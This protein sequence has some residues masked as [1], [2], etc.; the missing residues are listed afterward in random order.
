VELRT[1]FKYL[2]QYLF[3]VR[4]PLLLG[5]A[6]MAFP[7][8]APWKAPTFLGNLFQLGWRDIALVTF[9]ACLCAWSI[10]YTRR[11]IW[12]STPLR[13]GL[14]LNGEVHEKWKNDDYCHLPPPTTVVT[15]GRAVLSLLLLIP[16]VWT[17]VR[18]TDDPKSDA[19]WAVS[20]AIGA[21]LV[22]RWLGSRFALIP[23]VRVIP[24]RILKYT[25]YGSLHT[26]GT[27]DRSRYLPGYRILHWRA[28]LFGVFAILIFIGTGLLS[29]PWAYE[30]SVDPR[31]PLTWPIPALAYLIALYMV[32]VWVLGFVAFLFDRLR[33]PTIPLIVTVLV[34]WTIF[35]PFDH[36]YPVTERRSATLDSRAALTRYAAKNGGT[37]VLVAASGGGITASLWSAHVLQRLEKHIPD[38]HRKITLISAVSGGSV[39]TLYYVDGFADGAPPVM[40]EVVEASSDSSLS[41]A[42][43]G[44]AFIDAYRTVLGR[45]LGIWDRGWALEQRWGTHLANS[46]RTLGDWTDGVRAA[47]R[48]IALFNATVQETGERLI[49]SPV[50]IEP[51]NASGRRDLAEMLPGRDLKAVTA[52]RLSATFP[53]VSPHARPDVAPDFTGRSFRAVDGGYYDNSGIVSALDVVNDWLEKRGRAP[54]R[55][56][57]IEIRASGRID[58]GPLPDLKPD[59][60]LRT[61][62]APIET[63]LRMRTTSQLAR[64]QVEL[65]L[66]QKVWKSDY[67]V[68]LAHFTFRLSD[69]QPLSWHLTTSQ[70]EQIQSHWPEEDDEPSA[71]PAV[72]EAAADNRKAV[73]SLRAFLAPR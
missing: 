19:L 11:V 72:R 7:L 22:A 15:F 73:Q 44:F 41:A 25:P 62:G 63:L 27:V 71:P 58:Q 47:W 33:I 14:L 66:V 38:F 64:N 20:C 3:F 56:A 13:V 26:P 68:E 50:T 6:F 48:P 49:L 29:K 69:D 8:F 37:L 5:L 51:R 59:S 9:Y 16:L 65:R 53:Y 60:L 35:R 4:Y 61:A 17:L 45:V 40:K 30:A 23:P 57:L 10:E 34:I 2:P 39:G 42:V 28:F 1:R 43:W 55:I 32:L 31:N 70:I 12:V 21:A 67:D 46:E 54:T 24:E 52:A 36:R 18:G